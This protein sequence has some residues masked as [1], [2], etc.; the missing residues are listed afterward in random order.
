MTDTTS[1]DGAPKQ[2]LRERLGWRAERRPEPGFGHVLAAGGGAFAVFAV[3]ALIVEIGSDDLTAPGVLLTLALAAAAFVLAWKVDAGP[4]RSAAMAA[5]V[6]CVPLVWF[7]AF[8]GDG[9]TSGST[10]GVYLLIVASYLV[11]YVVTWTRGRALLLGLALLFLFG[12]ITSEIQGDTSIVPFQTTFEDQG[13]TPFETDTPFQDDTDFDDPSVFDEPDPTGASIAALVLGGLALGAGAL[14]DRRKLNGT[15][16]PLIAVGALYAITGA[17]ALGS[18]ES[19]LAG[20]LLAAAAGA[21]VGLVG[22]LGPHRRGSTW[23][24]VLAVV[25]GLVVVITDL[26]DSTLGFAAMAAVVAVVLGVVGYV[27]AP[28]LDEAPDGDEQA[29]AA[30]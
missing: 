8:Y 27:V 7:F 18:E 12:W 9:D 5:I 13:A 24:G 16:T 1:A 21:A 4:V 20:G 11:L 25:G 3:V 30:S 29:V 26:A 22:G 28:R 14:L 23:I 10:A 6:L 19:V 15:A 17:I 2:S